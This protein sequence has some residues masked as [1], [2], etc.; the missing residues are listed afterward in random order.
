MHPVSLVAKRR[1]TEKRKK[2]RKSLRREKDERNKIDLM[3]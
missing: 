3:C 2:L 1:E